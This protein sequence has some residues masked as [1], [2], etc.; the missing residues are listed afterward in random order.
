MTVSGPRLGI[1]TWPR[2]LLAWALARDL[3]A[4]VVPDTRLARS[5]G[6]DLEAAGLRPVA[7]PRHAT[8]LIVVGEVPPGL[9]AA[10]GVAY[11]QMPRPRTILAVGAAPILGLPPP[12]ATT[13]LDQ[14]GLMAGVA[15]LRRQLAEGAFATEAPVLD[16][17]AARTRTEF[18]CPM[19]PEV[20][21]NEPGSCPVCG[22][23]LVPREAAG[24]MARHDHAGIVPAM[25]HASGAAAGTEEDAAKRTYTCPMHPAVVQSGPGRC[26][27]CGMH[28]VPMGRA[29]DPPQ[30]A[31]SR[32]SGPDS[33]DGT[34]SS[35]D[36][37]REEPAG[38]VD[39]GHAG[40]AEQAD[41]HAGQDAL[42]VG[43]AGDQP[44]GQPAGRHGAAMRA[45]RPGTMMDH[46]SHV[47]SGMDHGAHDAPASST[48]HP[49]VG[50]DSSN[51]APM[52]GAGHLVAMDPADPARMTIPRTAEDGSGHRSPDH[53]TPMDHTA[54][55]PQGMDQGPMDHGAME[56]GGVDHGTMD[57]SPPGGGFMS[58]VAMT[59]ALPRSPD[60]LP[61]EWVEI[62]FGP[63]FAGLPGGLA[64]SFTLDGDGVARATV[65][66]G[67][68]ARGQRRGWPGPAETFPDR[69][70]RLDPLAPVAYRLLAQRAL[71]AV[72]GVVVDE[73]TARRRVRAAEWERVG[74]HLGWLAEFASLIGAT[75]LARRSA[76][77]QLAVVRAKDEDDARLAAEIRGFVRAG[78]RLP[79]LHRRLVGIGGTGL[80]LADRLRGPVARAAGIEVDARTDDPAYRGLGFGT[81]LDSGGD[82]LARLR[83]RLAEIVASL[84]LLLAAGAAA[85]PN[86]PPVPSGLLGS[87]EAMVETPR[88]AAR[89]RLTLERGAVIDAHVDPPSAGHIV[90][91]PGLVE[92]REVADA[93]VAI[94]S[95][96]LSP[97]EVDR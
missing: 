34:G 38:T 89:L 85:A 3:P 71:E 65:G 97:W 53:R 14:A 93:L 62:P 48:A 66:T 11:A 79:L 17:A 22:M 50:H 69:L 46:R 36:R 49:A 72:A 1:S 21:R 82:A 2:R 78:A 92:G 91:I 26:P 5:A 40:P 61:M 31:L 70:A 67:T 56:S 15:R 59:E 28:L 30:Q 68:T 16:L 87:A 86:A 88:G 95:L 39:D 44:A 57:H 51:H 13:T 43:V 23:D 60:G 75:W 84:D 80:D 29:D 33:G 37:A 83:V 54:T 42:A 35:G 8:V 96:D 63:L 74:S 12:D 47:D 64:L 77:L 90:L 18:V 20:V 58:M 94:A 52:G 73:P 4:F 24:A 27:I 19:H 32:R 9:A 25:A 45:A 55:G 10:A 81:S 76:Q 41:Q 7:T 6:L